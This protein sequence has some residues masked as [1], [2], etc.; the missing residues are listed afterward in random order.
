MPTN[1]LQG[2]TG[3]TPSTGWVDPTP[4]LTAEERLGGPANPAH[5][6]PG[7]QAEPYPWTVYP[8]M[9]PM[10]VGV[11]ND[12][13][14]YMPYVPEGGQLST[15]PIADLQ[16]ITHAAPWPR[17]LPQSPH[18]DSQAPWRAQVDEIRDS[19]DFGA[20]RKAELT[21]AGSNAVQDDWQQVLA[22]DP[23]QNFP[24]L[25]ELPTQAKTV[26]VMG[27]GS[28]DR[29]QSLARQNQYGADSAHM[30]RRFAVGHIPGNFLWLEG[31]SRPMVKSVPGTAQIPV[32]TYSPFQG[33]D[34]SQSFN[35]QGSV[36]Q[37]L[38]ASYTPTADPALAASYPG[39]QAEPLGLDFL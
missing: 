9:A 29:L 35:T 10:P 12:L 30:H 37:T 8:D 28:R 31:S 5:G 36:L 25:Q 26:G 17:G 34:T 24:G 21:G 2:L 14:G 3:L 33:Q 20:S 4:Q 23:G 27:W 39:T 15:D 1:S 13:L 19:S 16:P 11:E 6:V 7:E 32:G 38:P 22:T 18:P